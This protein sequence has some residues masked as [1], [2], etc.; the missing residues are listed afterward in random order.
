MPRFHELLII[1]SLFF[2]W[3]IGA[4]I[5]EAIDTVDGNFCTRGTNFGPDS[6]LEWTRSMKLNAM[7]IS[8]KAHF[9]SH[10]SSVPF[11]KAGTSIVSFY[12]KVQQIINEFRFMIWALGIRPKAKTK[13]KKLEENQIL[14][15]NLVWL[16]NFHHKF[17]NSSNWILNID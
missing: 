13:M 9:S 10:R 16:L 7:T 4:S 15:L 6:S 1:N 5:I 8:L 3:E 17:V 11:R 2:K 14:S 12:R